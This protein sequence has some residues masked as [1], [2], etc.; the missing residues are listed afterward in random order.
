MKKL[1]FLLFLIFISLI[2][3]QA[4]NW[5]PINQFD[6]YNYQI[7]T[8]EYIT[9]TVWANSV[10]LVGEDSIFYLNRIMTNCDTC[11]NNIN[12]YYALRNQPQ[13]LMRKMIKVSDSL[14]I[15]QDTSEFIIKPLLHF[16]EQWTFSSENN[17]QAIVS[18]E[19]KENIFGP[20]DS[21]KY[22]ALSNGKTIIISKN[23]GIVQFPF[24]NE[25]SYNLTGIEGNRELGEQVP[26]FWDFFNYDV[27]DIFQKATSFYGHEYSNSHIMKYQIISKNNLQDTIIYEIEVWGMSMVSGDGIY[28]DTT[29]AFYNSSIVFIDSANHFT[30]KY[31]HEIFLLNS[32]NQSL[33]NVYLDIYGKIVFTKNSETGCK[34]TG[35]F[36]YVNYYTISETNTDL[37]IKGEFDPLAVFFQYKEN[38]GLTHYNLFWGEISESEYLQGYVHNGDTTGTVYSDAF[39]EQYSDIK[40]LSDNKIRLYPNPANDVLYFDFLPNEIK[41]VHLTIYNITGK[42]VFSKSNNNNDN[43]IN[44]SSLNKGIYFLEIKT[45]HQ[46]EIRKFIKN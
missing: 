9:N 31:N 46:I 10:E 3:L 34:E 6:K 22:I 21:V 7:D 2:F 18:F 39:F 43:T 28:T 16:G 32:L 20:T 12:N 36:D 5:Q 1:L 38:K 25:I 4:Q 30:N 11:S 27:G 8:T 15:F 13:F 33:Q 35:N 14:F 19:G 41:N 40:K 42:N 26:N 23:Y 44:I 45:V 17:I 37:L 29:S 24:N